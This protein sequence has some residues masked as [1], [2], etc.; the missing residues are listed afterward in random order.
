MPVSY[1]VIIRIHWIRRKS[2]TEWIRLTCVESNKGVYIQILILLYLRFY[3]FVKSFYRSLKMFSLQCLSIE[4]RA[5]SSSNIL[6]KTHILLQI[7]QRRISGPRP[8][9]SVEEFTNALNKFYH[10]QWSKKYFS[11]ISPV[12]IERPAHSMSYFLGNTWKNNFQDAYILFN[13]TL[14]STVM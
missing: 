8:F 9:C 7:N 5:L 12:P 6:G 14:I 2:L 11:S 13:V 4:R 10:R 1:I 3:K